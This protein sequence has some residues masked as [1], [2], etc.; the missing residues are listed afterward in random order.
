MTPLADISDGDRPVNKYQIQYRI[1][2]R[3]GRF[4]SSHWTTIEKVKANTTYIVPIKTALLSEKFRLVGETEAGE[5][6][7]PSM[8]IIYPRTGMLL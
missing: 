7:I 5:T 8:E 4:W 2:P 3:Y 6:S 1:K